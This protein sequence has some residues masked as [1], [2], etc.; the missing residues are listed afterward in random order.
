MVLCAWLTESMAYDNFLHFIAHEPS[1]RMPAAHMN[2]TF[3]GLASL[4]NSIRAHLLVL[5]PKVGWKPTQTAIYGS[6]KLC[7]KHS[8]L[9]LQTGKY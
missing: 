9:K 4:S 2:A 3:V 1:S 8:R 7:A 5:Q 6:G